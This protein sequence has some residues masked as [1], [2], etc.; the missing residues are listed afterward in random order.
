MCRTGGRRCSRHDGAS[1]RDQQRR[2]AMR[3]YRADVVAAAA[4]VAGPHVL[5][6]LTAAPASALASLATELGLDPHTVSSV[7]PAARIKH[8][9]AAT[10][11]AFAAARDADAVESSA[12]PTASGAVPYRVPAPGEGPSAAALQKTNISVFEPPT[13]QQMLAVGPLSAGELDESEAEA[14]AKRR[15]YTA[16]CIA[17]SRAQWLTVDDSDRERWTTEEVADIETAR[18]SK[19]RRCEIRFRTS[20]GQLNTIENSHAL[21]IAD[22]FRRLTGAACVAPEFFAATAGN[23]EALAFLAHAGRCETPADALGQDVWERY[24]SR[25]KGNQEI[26]RNRAAAD[27]ETVAAEHA[28]AYTTRLTSE[29]D[30]RGGYTRATEAD[31]VNVEYLSWHAERVALSW[32]VD[33]NAAWDELPVA[34]PSTRPVLLDTLPDQREIRTGDPFGDY[35]Q[36]DHP[37]AGGVY[38][39]EQTVVEELS[40]HLREMMGS[41]E[42]AAVDVADA[43]SLAASRVRA[44]PTDTLAQ[45]VTRQRQ[46]VELAEAAEQLGM[47]PEQ[48]KDVTF[49][50]ANDPG[51]MSLFDEIGAL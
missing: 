47:Y 25:A 7:K 23:E 13:L 46:L 11:S 29:F 2:T 36:I 40:G 4:A 5:E 12:A 22:A 50:T 1:Q 21:D 9:I 48:A 19:R 39:P 42:P 49:V 28:V 31:Q 20:N 16:L 44:L 26:A 33:V 51:Q 41:A 35:D 43:I 14:A 8:D 38:L 45:R 30:S 6:V 32:Q 27:L 18:G 10:L 15:R 34:H 3:T 17:A 24:L 37:G